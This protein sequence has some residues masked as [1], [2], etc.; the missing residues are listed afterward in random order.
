MMNNDDE[1]FVSEDRVEKTLFRADDVCLIKIPPPITTDSTSS[2]IID[3]NS[4]DLNEIVWKGKLKFVETEF[5]MNMNID[6]DSINERQI[7]QGNII[8]INNNGITNDI[9]G[10]IPY[11]LDGHNV[12]I[13]NSKLIYSVILE[14][15]DKKLGLGLKFLNQTKSSDF[16]ISLQDFKKHAKAALDTHNDLINDLQ[17]N[18][19]KLNIELSSPTDSQIE[20]IDN[21]KQNELTDESDLEFGD[22]VSSE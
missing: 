11:T 7:I 19:Q 22:F 10:N 5:I 16:N 13:T 3:I 12:Q 20:H 9:F 8:L 17:E 21:N 2:S 6:E 14:F 1:F 15:Q 18:F 4:W